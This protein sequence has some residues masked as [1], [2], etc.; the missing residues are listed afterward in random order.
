MQFIVTAYDGKDSEAGARRSSV[1]EQHLAGAKKLV[2]ERKWLFAAALLDDEG[3]MMGS[4]M[5]VDFPSKDAL[6]SEW[7]D[8][9]PYVA[10]NVWEEID[11]RPCK[12][13]DFIL[14]ASLL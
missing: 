14:D 1:R 4:V 9:D 8:N 5:I 3:K 6:L 2:K 13:P 10:G 12:V 7:L 11:I